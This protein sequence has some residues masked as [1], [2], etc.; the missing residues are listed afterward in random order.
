MKTSGSK[1]IAERYVRALFEV[2]ESASVLAPVEKDMTAL[3][4]LLSENAEFRQFLINPLVPRDHQADTM[5]AVLAKV[6]AQPVTCQFIAMLSRQKRL[7]VLPEVVALFAEWAAEAR[8]EL[9]AEVISATPLKAKDIAMIGERL[10]AAYKKKVTLDVREDPELL[11][12][13]VVKIGSVQLD[14]SLA[15][16]MRRLKISLQAA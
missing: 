10:G 12:G 15:G 6:H 5:L 7:D 3:G 1:R 4:K 11:G 16:K 14:S 9:K 13:I 2:A 8:G